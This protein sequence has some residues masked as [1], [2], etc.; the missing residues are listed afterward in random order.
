MTTPT[1]PAGLPGTQNARTRNLLA[2]PRQLAAWA[3]V[4]YAGL[5]LAFAFLNWLL[6]DGGSLGRR[7][8]EAGF[9]SLVE[10]SFPVIA[11]LLASRVSPTLPQAKLITGIALAEYAI[12]IGFGTIAL[13]I[14]LGAMDANYLRPSDGL[15][16]VTYFVLGLGR[17]GLVL[18]AGFVTYQAYNALGG[19][20]PGKNS[21]PVE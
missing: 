2:T 17:L 19:S 21:A 16:V 8:A 13:L 14:G 10:L 7:S 4:G 1:P 11:V 5:H 3:L 12:A 20:L 15:D 9:T 18:L 6:P